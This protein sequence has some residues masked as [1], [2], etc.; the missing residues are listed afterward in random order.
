MPWTSGT[1][2]DAKREFVLLAQS[3]DANIRGLCRRFNVSP[4]TAY[5]VLNRFRA[6]GENGLQDLSRR[7]LHSPTRTPE[8]IE[9]AVLSL[10]ETHPL[11][12][13]R[14][15][16]SEL[17]SQGMIQVPAPSTVTNLLSRHGLLHSNKQLGALEWITASPSGSPML[18][19]GSALSEQPDMSIVLDHLLSK[20]VLER[21]RAIVI[22]SKWQG[23]RPSAVCNLLRL[24]PS[25]Y[26]RC[27][28]VLSEG[29][30]EALFARRKNPHRKYDDEGIKEAV[31][32]TLHQPP[33]NFGINRTTWKMEDLSRVLSEKGKPAGEGVLRKIIKS[34]GYR[35]RR[36]R[37]VL[38]SNDPEFSDKVRRIQDIL[39]NLAQD[40]SFFSID[41][42]GPFAI[43][44]QPGRSLV[45]PGEQRLVQQ[46]QRSRGSIILTAAI[47][48][49]SNQI[50]HF[51]SEGKNTAEMV[52]MMNLLIDQYRD[53]R[54]IYLS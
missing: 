8:P 1:T 13:G 50:S 30:A 45:A 39:A 16:A 21:R 42:Y 43:K 40:E 3:P 35:W 52:R 38:T 10:R 7:P 9:Q 11:W 5:K 22:L 34:A 19:H 23:L 41:E 14:K 36:A 33:S 53:S 37:V 15:I 51:Y 48:L 44:D 2:I 54:K 46:W 25:T 12:G 47:E 24:S 17:R 28:R 49:S 26:R 27:V 6:M 32:E 31:F 18:L 29:G 4:H 20:R